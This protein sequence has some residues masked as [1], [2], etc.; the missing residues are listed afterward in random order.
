VPKEALEIRLVKSVVA[1]ILPASYSRV[2]Y[3]EEGVSTSVYRLRGEGE[4]LY[5]RILPEADAS[6]APEVFAHTWL[7][8]QHVHVPEVLYFELCN[9][10]LQR[11]LMLTTEIPGTPLAAC[12][13]VQELRLA[14]RAAGRELAVINSLPVAGF[15]WVRREC[16][17]VTSLEAEH[18]SSRAF[19]CEHLEQDLSLLAEEVLERRER[20]T[21][22]RVID[23]FAGWLESKQSWLAH[24]DFDLT[25]IFQNG[26]QYSGIIDFGEMRGTDGFYDLGHFRI[27]DGERFPFPLLPWLLE[28][29]QE[30]A[31]LPPDSMQRISF[32]CML[33]AIKTL[34]RAWGKAPEKIGDHQGL[35]ALRREMAALQSNM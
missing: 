20:A 7:R 22:C 25:H 1:R 13:N 27:H 35:K 3:V 9:A 10:L 18:P 12:S 31:L 19:L 23:R 26:G 21:I 5:L 15:G 32:S 34:A 8:G 6:F 14:L 30:I 29:Y 2:E 4:T 11:S 28:G 33:I 24:G 16:R 17:E